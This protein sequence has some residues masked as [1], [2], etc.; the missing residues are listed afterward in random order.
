L[1]VVENEGT[2]ALKIKMN[3]L[4]RE[5]FHGSMGTQDDGVVLYFN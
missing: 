5:F 3:R 1:F 2:D 4:K